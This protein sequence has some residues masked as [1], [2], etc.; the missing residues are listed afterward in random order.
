[1][2][3]TDICFPQV[4]PPSWSLSPI[5]P[6]LQ[7]NHY[8]NHQLLTHLTYQAIINVHQTFLRKTDFRS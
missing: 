8:T 3:V 4:I 7:V 5:I 6:G 2:T 1:M